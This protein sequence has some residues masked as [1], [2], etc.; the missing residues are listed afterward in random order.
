MMS[1]GNILDEIAP[2]SP[3]WIIRYHSVA[4]AGHNHQH[5][6]LIHGAS[7]IGFKEERKG[8]DTLY[9]HGSL[10]CS[11][12]PCYVAIGLFSHIP[13]LPSPLLHFVCSVVYFIS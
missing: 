2:L 5:I 11:P 8:E 3:C 12:L 4:S 7:E 10:D 13:S 9:C 1:G 6:Y